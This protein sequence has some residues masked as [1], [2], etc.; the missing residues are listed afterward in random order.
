MPCAGGPHPGHGVLRPGQR[1]GAVG[2]AVAGAAAVPGGQFSGA[3]PRR[4][5]AVGGDPCLP[6][7]IAGQSGPRQSRGPRRIRPENGRKEPPG[8][9]VLEAVEGERG[10]VAVGVIHAADFLP[11]GAVHLPVL[12]GEGER[13]GGC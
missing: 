7:G 8:R 11:D 10:A 6:A 12:L 5:G 13:H 3:V 9:F 1:G 4:G 2:G